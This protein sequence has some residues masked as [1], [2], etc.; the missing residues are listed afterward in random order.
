M[1]LSLSD[2]FDTLQVDLGSLYV[3]DLNLFGRT[4]QVN[5]QA[6][7]PFRMEPDDIRRL[8]VRN[9]HGGMVPLT[10][11]ATVQNSEA[12]FLSTATTPIPPRRSTATRPGASASGEAIAAM[13]CLAKGGTMTG[14]W[15]ELAYLQQI[16]GSTTGL[17]FGGA[18]ILVFLVLAGQY[19][20]WSLPLA[21]ILVVPMCIL[22][23]VAGV[24]IARMDINLFT[25]IG[26]VVLV[27]LA[28]KNAIL[29]VEFARASAN[30]ALPA[31]KPRWPPA[32]SACGRSS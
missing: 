15:T 18:V 23:S 25:Q 24:A 19:E 7:T 12:P 28:S 17:A 10:P 26:F 27:G 1:G 6:D 11:R 3:N 8:H 9:P 20:S 13:D 16:A 2:V 30:R 14:E 31:T 21:V 29:I 32:G 5:V 4:W 22:C